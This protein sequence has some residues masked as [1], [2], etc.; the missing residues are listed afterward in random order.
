MKALEVSA[1]ID[2]QHRLQGIV[3]PDLRPGRVRV[4]ILVPEEDEAGEAWE[5]GVARQWAAELGDVRE[6]IYTV[7][8]GE[9]E[10]AAR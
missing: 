7:N 8:D 5:R 4:I 10:D 2:D 9:P 6:D 1:E 3:P